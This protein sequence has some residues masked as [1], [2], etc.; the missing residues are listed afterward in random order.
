M[1][2]PTGHK[3][4][5]EVYQAIRFVTKVGV[6]SR[7]TWYE[8]FGSGSLRWK[9]KQLQRLIELGIF[10]SHPCLHVDDVMTIG[11]FGKKLIEEKKWSSVPSVSAQFIEHDEIVARGVWKLEQQGICR[12]WLTDKE[13]KRSGSK[14]FQLNTKDIG[15][16]FPDIVFQLNRLEQLDVV[17]V[18]YEKT[19]KS[20]WRYNKAIKSYSESLEFDRVLYIVESKAIE[21]SVKRAMRFIGDSNLN[22]K[23]FFIQSEDWKQNPITALGGSMQKVA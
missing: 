10:K 22:R 7:S 19:A 13:M 8:L 5:E 6:M 3:V 14:N 20:N 1:R 11:D 18:E 2:F 9:Q 12:R 16:K 17:A 15:S 21:Q 23:I 4:S